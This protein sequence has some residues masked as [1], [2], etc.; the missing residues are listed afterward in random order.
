MQTM[1]EVDFTILAAN[2]VFGDLIEKCPPAEACRDAF[3]RTA[4]ATI[5]M[6]NSTGG[7]GQSLRS[8]RPGSRDSLDQRLDWSSRSDT[9]TSSKGHG[10]KQHG[11][12]IDQ[13]PSTLGPFDLGSETYSNSGASSTRQQ[14]PQKPLARLPSLQSLK[15]DQDLGT[16]GTVD[17][18]LMPSPTLAQNIASPGQGASPIT[19][20]PQQ[21]AATQGGSAGSPSALTPG[22]GSYLTAQPQQFSPG[23]M[24]F[25]DLQGMEFLQS[26]NNGVNRVDGDLNQGD[27]QMDLGFGLGWEGMH[28][29]F[30][31][32]QQVDL[33]DGFFFGGQQGGA[34]GAGAGGGY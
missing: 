8:T 6:A 32:G 23:A 14:R 22:L 26:L 1:D 2:S 24:N 18:S 28:H 25:G 9:S 21:L 5:K 20:L 10:Q 15:Q 33:F 12:P 19:G 31:D 13:G 29:D 34:G 3:D 4:K 30:S 17:P 11:R 7:F 27:A 16:D